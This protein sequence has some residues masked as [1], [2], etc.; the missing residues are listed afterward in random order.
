MR[1]RRPLPLPPPQPPSP[2]PRPR[3]S[4]LPPPLPHPPARLRRLRGCSSTLRRRTTSSTGSVARSCLAGWLVM[5][6][7]W[8]VGWLA[9]HAWLSCLPLCCAVTCVAARS[10]L[11]CSTFRLHCRACHAGR[12]TPVFK[13]LPPK[14]VKSWQLLVA[15]AGVDAQRDLH[16]RQAGVLCQWQGLCRQLR[17]GAAGRVQQARLG[18][19]GQAGC[20][21][22]GRQEERSLELQTALLALFPPEF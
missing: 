13:R 5:P 21:R 15:G 17:Q 4:Q 8:L 12:V 18:A 1:R 16:M 10:V 20:S 11:R 22:P 9:G 2:L 6:A 14:H 7:G 3:P 19:A